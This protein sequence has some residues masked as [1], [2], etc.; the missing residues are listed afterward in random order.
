M[1]ELGCGWGVLLIRAVEASYPLEKAH[2]ASA[3]RPAGKP[4][5]AIAEPAPLRTPSP[6]AKAEEGEDSTP[7]AIPV[8]PIEAGA[9]WCHFELTRPLVGTSGRSTV[10]R[11]RI[12]AFGSSSATYRRKLAANTAIACSSHNRSTPTD[13]P[14][15]VDSAQVGNYVTDDQGLRSRIDHHVRNYLTYD[16]RMLDLSRWTKTC[17]GIRV[18]VRRELPHFGATLEAFEIR[19]GYRYQA[20]TT[21]TRSG[22]LAFLKARHRANARVEHRIRTE[23]GTGLSSA[24]VSGTSSVP[25]T[26]P[27]G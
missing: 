24:T 5:A 6:N 25:A 11:C 12:A 10:A 26:C 27:G 2:S 1:L 23:N 4:P 9:W 22:Q 16:T 3:T 21:N 19:V 7:P 20:W 14:T 15:F 17:P 13:T 18:I 8:G